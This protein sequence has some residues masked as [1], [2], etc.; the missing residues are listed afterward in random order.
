M[1]PANDRRR[2]IVTSS[3]IGWAH[4]QND[5]YMCHLTTRNWSNLYIIPIESI[6]TMTSDEN[7]NLKSP[8]NWLFIQQLVQLTNKQKIKVP[9]R[10]IFCPENASTKCRPFCSDCINSSYPE[11]NDRHFADDI[12]RCIFS[13]MKSFCILIKISLK[14]VPEGPINNN[15]ALVQIM[16]WRRIGDK[17]LSAPMLTWSTDAYMRH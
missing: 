12:F 17:P 2:Y 3:L 10:D 7:Q 14:F 9:H 15:P 1:R 13:W 5:P 16:A 8:V 4:S 6:Y 11:Q